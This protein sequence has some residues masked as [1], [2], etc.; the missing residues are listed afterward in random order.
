MNILQLNISDLILNR[1]DIYLNLGYYGTRPDKYINEM[2]ENI[3][4][5]ASKICHPQ[6]GYVLCEGSVLDSKNILINDIS[7]KIGRI[8]SNYLKDAT[9]FAV[10]VTTAGREYDEYLKQLKY[11]GDIMLEFL[12]DAVG[13]EIAEA[14]VRYV[15][16]K[17]AVDTAKFDYFTTNSYSPGYCGWHVREQRKLFSL[18]P[19]EPCGIILNDSC[20][21]YPVKSVSGLVG[22][23]ENIKFMPY[24]CEICGLKTCYKKK[25][26]IF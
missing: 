9:H 25:N 4:C 10:F 23:G 16:Q 24:S 7:M 3:I 18:L 11:S 6:A 20:L 8:I 22:I 17:I 5:K 14:A 12:A 21:M 26:K 19:N 13:S 15:T 1:E 2:L